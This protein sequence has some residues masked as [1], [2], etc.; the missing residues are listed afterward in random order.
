MTL[1]KRLGFTRI[2]REDGLRQVSVTGDVDPAVT[3][4]NVVF[5]TVRQ[6]ISPAIEKQFDVQVDFKGKAEEQSEALG[7]LSIALIVSITCIYIILA[8][9]FASYTMPLVIMAVVPFGLIGALSH[10]HI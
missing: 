7:D 4:A 1:T 5:A 8:W 3:P 10:I 9:L 6:E 2:N